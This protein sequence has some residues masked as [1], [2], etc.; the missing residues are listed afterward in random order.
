[1]G[2]ALQ[3]EIQAAQSDPSRA[4]DVRNGRQLWIG[5]EG[6][7]YEFRSDIILPFQ[8]DAPVRVFVDRHPPVQG[9]VVAVEDFDLTLVL[10]E[11]IGA[12]VPHARVTSEPW[13]ILDQLRRKF[14]AELDR[15]AADAT[16]P[17]A[18][19]GLDTL[20]TTRDYTGA[21]RT[22]NLLKNTNNPGLQPN[23]AQADAIAR[24]LGSRLHFVWGPP[25]TGVGSGNS[26]RE[27][28]EILAG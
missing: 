14:E 20:A 21:R 3:H 28:P 27:F 24:C 10:R 25:G 19:L 2:V 1:M 12:E 4:F 26:G 6:H 11:E 7:L 17:A 16:I 15:T 5:E 18:L 9:A 13:F 8:A 23:T 22:H